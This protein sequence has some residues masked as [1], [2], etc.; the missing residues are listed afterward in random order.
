MS[1]TPWRAA[2]AVFAQPA[3]SS[4]S[5]PSRNTA[6]S[7]RM[8]TA[9]AFVT[10]CFCVGRGFSA[11]V[12]VTASFVP[13]QAASRAGAS[14]RSKARRTS[15]EGSDARIESVLGE[16]GQNLAELRP[17][18]LALLRE[19]EVV[20][21]EDVELAL[22]AGNH[23]GGVLHPVDLS[24]ETRGSLVVAVSDGAVQHAHVS[25]AEQP[26][27]RARSDGARSAASGAPPTCPPAPAGTPA[28]SR[29]PPARSGPLDACRAVRVRTRRACVHP[30]SPCACPT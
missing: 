16:C 26:T 15:E 17:A 14:S 13:P 8:Q 7:E 30:R 5:R 22:L 11:V 28:R 1:A 24:H 27:R 10:N 3:G 19:H 20:V 12:V 29:P 6:R 21:D 25:H 18:T 9:F 23:L 2:A 4:D